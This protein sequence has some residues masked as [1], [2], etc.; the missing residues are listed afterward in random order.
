MLLILLLY[1]SVFYD[2][3]KVENNSYFY[4][5]FT[6]SRTNLLHMKPLKL[7]ATALGLAVV[8]SGF[9]VEQKKERKENKDKAAK[10]RVIQ[11]P[12]SVTDIDKNPIMEARVYINNNNINAFCT[13][14]MGIV[15]LICK[16][17]DTLYIR[18]ENYISQM[19]PIKNR[20]ELNVVL[21]KIPEDLLPAKDS[22][23]KK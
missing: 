23:E 5:K 8:V 16:N 13:N 10:E 11:L 2:V 22:T 19:I 12:V 9:S 18:K 4:K 20:Y 7:I 21:E 1:F 14:E 3:V 15:T 6:H 17:F